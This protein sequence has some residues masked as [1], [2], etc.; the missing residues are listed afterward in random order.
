MLYIHDSSGTRLG[1]ER[2]KLGKIALEGMAAQ[3]GNG[4]RQHKGRSIR[5][6]GFWILLDGTWACEGLRTICHGRRRILLATHATRRFAHFLTVEIL[7]VTV[8]FLLGSTELATAAKLMLLIWDFTSGAV[9]AKQWDQ[10]G[11][12][13]KQ[14]D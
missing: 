5:D 6:T 3:S 2:V 4:A 8:V 7:C 10:T 12:P 14:Y 13:Q 9:P 1:L 11:R